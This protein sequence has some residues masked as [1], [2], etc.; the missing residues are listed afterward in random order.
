MGLIGTNGAGKTT[1]VNVISGYQRPSEG[2]VVLGGRDV[3]R[4]AA[5]RL[6][7]A[8]VVR[9]FQAGRVFPAL[10]VLENIEAAGAATGNSRKRAR[11]RAHELLERVGMTSHSEL[12]ASA[13]PHG[14]IRI[15]GILRALATGPRYMLVDEPAAGSNETESQR[16]LDLLR[17]I[18]GEHE[19]GLL[20]IEHDMTLIM[21]LCHEIQ[22]LDHGKTI[23]HGTPESVR[24]DPEVIRAYLGTEERVGDAAPH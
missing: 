23:A 17:W 16:L 21:R 6:A 20:V 12:P 24:S 1:L 22:V 11:A 5:E 4:W 18:A 10:S 14:D 3:T 13:L 2:R 8:G 19:I 7:V 15:L 9:T